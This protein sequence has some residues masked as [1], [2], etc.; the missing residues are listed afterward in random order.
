MAGTEPVATPDRPPVPIVRVGLG[1]LLILGSASSATL[2][3][4][5]GD[6]PRARTLLGLP[7][8]LT[9]AC[10]MWFAIRGSLN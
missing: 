3:W 6:S 4:L 9:G 8:M 2:L 10:G 7:L 1:L 5:E